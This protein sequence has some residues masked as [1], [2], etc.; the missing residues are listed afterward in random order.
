MEN[1]II[2]EV[3]KYYTDKIRQHGATPAGVDW[4]STESQE[5]RFGQLLKIVDVDSSFS[6]LDYGCGFGSLFTF[7]QEK[8]KDFKFTGFDI[9]DEMLTAAKKESRSE[10]AKWINKLETGQKFDFVVASGIFNVRQQFNDEK[11]LAYIYETLDTINS[12]STKG[13]S[14][15]LL[16]SYSDKE[17]MKDYLYYADPMKLFD[18]C[19][20]KYSKKVAILHDYP[21]YE[22]TLLV[23]K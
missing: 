11:W 10:T 1:K 14:V 18:H 22:F 17:Y 23:R 5:M 2:N 8:Y 12:I 9:S 3:N 20:K 16:T 15:N 21:L 6:I 7:M 4:N 19:K 13:F